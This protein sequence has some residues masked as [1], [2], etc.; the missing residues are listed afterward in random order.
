MGQSQSIADPQGR[1]IHQRPLENFFHV[2]NI[3]PDTPQHK[4]TEWKPSSDPPMDQTKY[5]TTKAKHESRKRNPISHHNSHG[6]TTDYTTDDESDNLYSVYRER[7]HHRRRRRERKREKR[8]SETAPFDSSYNQELQED[9]M[10]DWSAYDNS[11]NSVP[12]SAPLM[13]DRRYDLDVAPSMVNMN[14]QWNGAYMIVALLYNEIA[15]KYG[16]RHMISIQHLYWEAVRQYY[17]LPILDARGHYKI[18]LTCM[19]DIVQKSTLCS[20]RELSIY[21]KLTKPLE[22]VNGGDKST[23]TKGVPECVQ[24]PKLSK[25]ERPFYKMNYYTISRNV[26]TLRT[27]LQENHLI[28]ANLTLF[29]NF[30]STAHGV[31]PCPNQDDTPVGM[32][33][34]ILVGYD[35]HNNWWLVRF[36]FGMHWGDQGIGY[37]TETYFE[38]YNRDR[39]I[40]DVEEC[41]EPPE[42]KQQRQREQEHGVPGRLPVHMGNDVL[43]TRLGIKEYTQDKLPQSPK[44]SSL[45]SHRSRL[46][47]S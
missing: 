20:E 10:H 5:N 44:R 28:L 13:L 45:H 17:Q 12:S 9:D 37:V 26:H 47:I 23:L 18:S 3:I 25:H 6:S 46:R 21:T 31:V 29:S 43:H 15:V 7:S 30:L 42:Y 16:Y 22:M 1:S 4:H 2:C 34:I 8:I 32:I 14:L 40:V 41:G 38:E 27:A 24:L 33:A 39:W 36:P 35:N 19:L 11:E